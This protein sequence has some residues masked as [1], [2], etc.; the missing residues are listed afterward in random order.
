MTKPVEIIQGAA[1]VFGVP[2]T[3]VLARPRGR[4][5]VALG[6]MAAMAAIYA[7]CN[8]NGTQIGQIF[9]GRHHTTVTYACRTVSDRCATDINFKI[10]FESLL[11]GVIKPYRTAAPF[12]TKHLEKT[13]A[14]PKTV[15]LNQR[16][17][18]DLGLD[19]LAH[20]VRFGQEIPL[21]T[22]SP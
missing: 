4:E 15:T 17:S 19:I 20:H 21:Q 11:A 10:S 5:A 18:I 2:A 9:S 13:N 7:K 1:K 12:K 16:R 22:K 8:L 6:R 3:A 14:I